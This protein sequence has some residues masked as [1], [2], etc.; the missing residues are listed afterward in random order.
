MIHINLLPVRQIKQRLQIRN[1]I[2]IYGASIL[3]LFFAIGSVIL[4]QNLTL[5]DLTAQNQFLTS[6][7]ASYQPILNEIEKLKKDKREQETKL[8]VIKKLKSGSQITVHVMDELA[9]LTPTNRLW[10]TSLTQ[11]G[12][13]VNISGIALDNATIAQFMQSIN[14]SD[15]FSGA[16]LSQTSQT[17]I[18]GAKLKS[19]AMAIGITPPNFN[20]EKDSTEEKK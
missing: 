15:Y 4:G 6:K 7:K 12:E 11:S 19:F 9:K 10:L 5:K 13:R 20:Q 2:A 16:E 3:F 8:E 14:E 17:T 1:E 18:A